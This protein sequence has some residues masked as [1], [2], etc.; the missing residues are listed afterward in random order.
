MK[1]Y[2]QILGAERAATPDDLKKAYRKLAQQWHPDKHPD[3]GKNEAEE[4]F[5]EIAEAYSVLADEEKRRNYDATGSPDGRSNFNYQTA[6]DPFEIFRRMGGFNM[7]FGPQQPR[8]MKGQNIQESVE[9][10]LRDSLF[11][12]EIP[13]QFSMMSACEVCEG[14]GSTEFDVCDVCKGQGGITQQQGNMIMHHTCDH[15]RGQGRRAKSAC[16]GCSGRGVQQLNRSLN[17]SIPKGVANGVNLRL[18]GQG[19]RGFRGG[20]S[21]DL[22]LQIRVKYPDVDSLSQEERTQLEQ[23][24]SK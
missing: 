8:P 2:Y 9:I 11:G 22:L 4:K 23:L 24:L 13:I 12:V 16:G 18:A 6:G 7:H 5:K 19:G 14:N 17:I 15:C 20:P 21:G 10:S 1:D 3:E